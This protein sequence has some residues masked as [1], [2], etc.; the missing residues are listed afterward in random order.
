MAVW[1][2]HCS[3]LHTLDLVGELHPKAIE[4]WDLVTHCINSN[5]SLRTLYIH[6]P[7]TTETTCRIVQWIKSRDSSPSSASSMPCS[8]LREIAVIT[9]ELSSSDVVTILDASPETLERFVVYLCVED[10]SALDLQKVK[11]EDKQY[12]SLLEFTIHVNDPFLSSVDE[13]C[14]WRIQYPIWRQSP[15]Q[16]TF[17]W[18]ELSEGRKIKKMLAFFKEERVQ[19]SPPGSVAHP[20]SIVLDFRYCG[21]KLKHITR[22]ISSFPQDSICNVIMDDRLKRQILETALDAERE[23]PENLLF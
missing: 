13:D 10:V 2:Q 9:N 21:L 3:N 6:T 11:I 19:R 14:F 20:P 1:V 5:P 16:T 15:N 8:P 17:I 18:P 7:L 23:N 12:P 4:S 22:I